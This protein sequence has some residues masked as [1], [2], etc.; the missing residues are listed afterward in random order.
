MPLNTQILRPIMPPDGDDDYEILKLNWGH[1]HIAAMAIA[2]VLDAKD[3]D[4][5]PTALLLKGQLKQYAA[6]SMEA[7]TTGA[8]PIPPGLSFMFADYGVLGGIP[9]GNGDVILEG[10]YRFIDTGYGEILQLYVGDLLRAS[11]GF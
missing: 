11:R 9:L 10:D 7:A 2:S 6:D 8:F 3:E 4:L 1:F 5:L